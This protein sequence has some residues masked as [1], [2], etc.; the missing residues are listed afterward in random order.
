MRE[1]LSK[2]P[3]AIILRMFPLAV[4]F[5][6][7]CGPSP[8]TTAALNELSKQRPDTDATTSPEYNFSLFTG[9]VWKTKVELALAE[10]KLY[11]GR[12][13]L[14][15]LTPENFEPTH[16]KYRPVHDSSIIAT[17]PKGT[18]LRIERLMKDN[19]IAGLLW[20]TATIEVGTNAQKTVHVDADML[21]KN[22]FIWPGWSSSTNWDVNPDMLE[23]Q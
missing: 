17:L 7:G 11:T 21:G 12:R 3:Q 5:V 2:F 6:L 8:E 20:V 18:K 14:A 13:D 19:G 9:T 16:P 22:K 10:V 15:L 1:H 4:V 23:K